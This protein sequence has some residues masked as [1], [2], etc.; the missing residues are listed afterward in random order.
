MVQKLPTPI[1]QPL[2]NSQSTPPTDILRILNSVTPGTTLN[3]YPFMPPKGI[4]RPPRYSALTKST[5]D[6]QIADATAAVDSNNS[7][8]RPKQARSLADLVRSSVQLNEEIHVSVVNEERE[9]SDSVNNNIIFHHDE[10]EDE[11]DVTST[12]DNDE[13]ETSDA[14]ETVGSED[15]EILMQLGL[16]DMSNDVIPDE[17]DETQKGSFRK[18]WE[19]LIQWATPATTQL[20]FQYNNIQDQYQSEVLLGQIAPNPN[21][22]SYDSHCRNTIE[23]G[24]S[25]RAGIMNMIRMNVSRSLSEL[26]QHNEVTDRRIVEKRL[27]DLVNTFDCSGPV[28]DLDT[29]LWRGMTTVLIASLSP[30]VIDAADCNAAKLLPPSIINLGLLPD[31]YRYLTRRAL[32]DLSS[33]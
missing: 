2:N 31:E 12:E 23:A 15:D 8:P 1:S 32:V 33:N 3:Y 5:E 16:T 9:E 17:Y 25:R 22:H 28:V 19:I 29:K 27:A 20:I 4:L 26:K 11:D 24:A 13:S 10:E 21:E 30:V 6:A 18:L 7:A 14:S